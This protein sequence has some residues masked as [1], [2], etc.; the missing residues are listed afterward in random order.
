M[1]GLGEEEYKVTSYVAASRNKIIRFFCVSVPKN[2]FSLLSSIGAM[3]FVFHLFT[4]IGFKLSS[5]NQ[6]MCILAHSRRCGIYFSV[7][8]HFFDS[9]K[10]LSLRLIG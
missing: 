3:V 6:L 10:V 1:L 9:V 2:R 7:F 4:E 8:V 5:F